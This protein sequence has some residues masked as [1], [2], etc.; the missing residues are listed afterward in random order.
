[1]SEIKSGAS[2]ISERNQK[3][4]R[5]IHIF[6]LMRYRLPLAGVVSILHRIS[7]ALL[8]FML[9]F[10]LYLLEKSLTSELS[11]EHF[12]GLVSGVWTKIILLALIWA[13]LHHF[14]AGIRHLLMDV[15]M[16]LEKNCARKSAAMVLLIS[17]PLTG[18]I[19]LKLFGVF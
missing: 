13:Y 14:L 10:I 2:G 7:G 12:K 4:F 16:G 1:M 8:F 3:V 17:I 6:D 5:N 11:F 15:H 9:P 19:G 18:L